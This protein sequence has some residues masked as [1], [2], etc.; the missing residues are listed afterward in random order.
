MLPYQPSYRT[1][2]GQFEQKELNCQAARW[3]GS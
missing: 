2:T 1:A 3:R